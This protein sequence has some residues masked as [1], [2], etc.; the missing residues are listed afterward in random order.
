M[1]RNDSQLYY[2][3]TDCEEYIN[4]SEWRAHDCTETAA[5]PDPHRYA[6]LCYDQ[7]V[8]DPDTTRVNDVNEALDEIV[9][10]FAADAWEIGDVYPDAG[11]GDTPTDELITSAVYRCLHLKEDPATG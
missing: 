4:T 3:C 5:A 11:I 7:D 1:P 9:R 2:Y 6:L 10:N 8:D